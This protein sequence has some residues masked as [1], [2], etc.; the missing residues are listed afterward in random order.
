V[1]AWVYTG[2]VATLKKQAAAEAKALA[3]A[4]E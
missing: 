4:K 2:E 3:A 1:K